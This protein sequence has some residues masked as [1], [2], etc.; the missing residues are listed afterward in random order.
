MALALLILGMAAVTYLTRYTLV[1][2]LGHWRLPP[3][4]ERWLGHVPTAV[5]TAIVVQGTFAPRGTLELGP[6][7]PY[8]WGA[9]AAGVVSWRT[10]SV[11][12]AI[13]AGLGGLWLARFLL[14]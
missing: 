7:N 8:L 13:V 6:T 10:R 12:L 11:L 4:L 9:M 2:L 5:F 3:A 14:A 1:A